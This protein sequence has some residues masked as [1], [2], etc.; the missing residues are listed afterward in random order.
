MCLVL[1][2][3]DRMKDAQFSTCDRSSTILKEITQSSSMKEQK[4]AILTWH[5]LNRCLLKAKNKEAF[6][7][8]TAKS[9]A[10]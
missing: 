1:T 8:Q 10:T 5:H 3:A 6:Q 9:I 2:K 4:P 7:N